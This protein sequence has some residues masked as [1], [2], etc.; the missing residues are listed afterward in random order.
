MLCTQAQALQL[1]IASS[2]NIIGGHNPSSNSGNDKGNNTQISAND[3]VISE[4]INTQR[5][6]SM[7]YGS[8]TRFGATNKQLH[9][10]RN[11]HAMKMIL[12]KTV[13]VNERQLQEWVPKSRMQC[14]QAIIAQQLVDRRNIAALQQQSPAG[15]NNVFGLLKAAE[16]AR[17]VVIS[18][19]RV[20]TQA[21]GTAADAKRSPDFIQIRHQRK[22]ARKH[23]RCHNLASRRI[24]HIHFTKES[25]RRECGSDVTR[26]KRSQ[27]QVWQRFKS[28]TA[29][30]QTI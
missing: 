21:L 12:R 6:T 22:K 9:H 28:I 11:A 26:Q 16:R 2:G 20:R 8:P 24:L 17:V 15:A 10:E 5:A 14:A 19:V 3:T 7:Q 18:K 27:Y 23:A 4:S 1:V 30:R 29:K 25:A 13:K